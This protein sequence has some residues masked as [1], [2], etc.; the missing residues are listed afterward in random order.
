VR[1]RQQR[2]QQQQF[3]LWVQVILE[4]VAR[5]SSRAGEA[6]AA[7]TWLFSQSALCTCQHVQVC[8]A[9]RYGTC[10]MYLALL[11]RSGCLVFLV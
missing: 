8:C 5:R 9:M 3:A 2:Q 6:A 10:L 1:Q 4:H 7:A 11:L